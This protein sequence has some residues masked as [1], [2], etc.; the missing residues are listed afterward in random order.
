MCYCV[1]ISKFTNFMF[2]AV[3]PVRC[4]KLKIFNS[5]VS[6]LFIH[7]VDNFFRGEVSTKT[8]LHHK[9]VLH[10]IP[11]LGGEWMIR[12]INHNVSFSSVSY[13]TFPIRMIFPL[14]T[15]THLK[16][17]FRGMFKTFLTHIYLQT[18]RPIS[19]CLEKTVRSLRT[20][21]GHIVDIKNPSFL[22]KFIIQERIGLSI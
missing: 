22:S 10:D 7:M 20:T 18:K 13:S 2:L 11:R 6:Y 19:S 4:K 12:R 9:A 5:I 14:F 17:S 1:A 8:F 15:H 16:D 3:D 21:L